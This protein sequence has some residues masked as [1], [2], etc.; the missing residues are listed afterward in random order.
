MWK[1]SNDAAGNLLRQLL[2]Q[3]KALGKCEGSW[4]GACF[5]EEEEDKILIRIPINN[6]GFGSLGRRKG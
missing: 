5:R 1:E 4:C 2:G 3:V 6:G